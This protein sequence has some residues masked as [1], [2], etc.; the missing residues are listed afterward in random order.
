[1]AD[2]RSAGNAGVLGLFETGMLLRASVVAD[3]DTLFLRLHSVRVAK[4]H[5]AVQRFF[6]A[7][8]RARRLD[9]R[10]IDSDVDDEIYDYFLHMTARTSTVQ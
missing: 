7:A 1:M 5:V 6:F 9:R 2:G 10:G 3:G 4:V 8:P